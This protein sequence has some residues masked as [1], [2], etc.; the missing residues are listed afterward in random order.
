MPACHRFV[1]FL[2]LLLLCSL[3]LP[4]SQEVAVGVWLTVFTLGWPWV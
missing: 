1:E 4:E 3:P 2:T